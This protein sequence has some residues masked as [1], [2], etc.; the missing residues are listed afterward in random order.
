MFLMAEASS[1]A[2]TDGPAAMSGLRTREAV[3]TIGEQMTTV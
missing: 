2:H 3:G 1:L